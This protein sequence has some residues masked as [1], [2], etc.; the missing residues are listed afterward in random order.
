MS[1]L[2]RYALR[3]EGGQ[4]KRYSWTLGGEETYGSYSD[5]K[6]MGRSKYVTIVKIFALCLD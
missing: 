4:Y 3:S 2:S 1:T 5:L 6:S